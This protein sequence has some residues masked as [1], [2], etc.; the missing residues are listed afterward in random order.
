MHTE[1]VT[2]Y[3]AKMFS[4]R[5]STANYITSDVEIST[6]IRGTTFVPKVTLGQDGESDD[7]EEEIRH[8][9]PSS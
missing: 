2:H 5:F 7:G 1:P 6:R 4:L 3:L 8:L 9:Q